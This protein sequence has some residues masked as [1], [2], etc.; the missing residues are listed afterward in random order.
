MKSVIDIDDIV[1]RTN[2]VVSTDMDDETVMMSIDKGM[3]YGLDTIATR[4]WEL[5]EKPLA[6]SDLCNILLSEFEVDRD[7]CQRDVLR[8]LNEMQNDELI[9]VVDGMDQ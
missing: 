4:I 1:I 7:N 2:E 3:Y 8:F 6:V 9:K 5:I